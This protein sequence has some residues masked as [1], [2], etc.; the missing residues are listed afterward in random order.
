MFNNIYLKLTKCDT[1]IGDAAECLAV[2]A[3]VLAAL[4]NAASAD[5]CLV[6]FRMVLTSLLSCSKQKNLVYLPNTRKS[7]LQP[8]S[9]TE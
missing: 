9:M 8:F 1:S 3:G 7:V 2:V 6:I 4:S 5:T